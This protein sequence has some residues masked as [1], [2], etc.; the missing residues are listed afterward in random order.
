M[1]Q[2]LCHENENDSHERFLVKMYK[3]YF[4]LVSKLRVNI[5]ANAFYVQP[6]KDGRFEFKNCAVGIHSLNNILPS[7]C[8]AI[9]T[10]RKTRH[11]L[12][13]TCVTQLFNANVE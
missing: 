1:V 7:L 6:F 13:V 11:S 9:G 3:R 12:R 2:H 5:K 4:E 10:K 8:G